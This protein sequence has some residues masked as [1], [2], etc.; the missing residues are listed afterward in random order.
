MFTSACGLIDWIRMYPQCGLGAVTPVRCS[1]LSGSVTLDSCSDYPVNP[2]RLIYLHSSL[3]CRL[4]DVASLFPAA[5]AAL[6]SVWGCRLQGCH[7]HPDNQMGR[8][9][10]AAGGQVRH[11]ST[12]A[13]IWLHCI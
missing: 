13:A 7:H 2:M 1:L 9:S 3:R 11:C 12:I 4:E 8:Y 10:S 5:V 6:C